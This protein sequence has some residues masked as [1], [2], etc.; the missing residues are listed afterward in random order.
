[1]ANWDESLTVG[2]LST[3]HIQ[4]KVLQDMSKYD[5]LNLLLNN[6]RRA[7]KY[8]AACCCIALPGF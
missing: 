1:M 7:T 5:Q 2:H 3:L 4:S 6:S 8:V